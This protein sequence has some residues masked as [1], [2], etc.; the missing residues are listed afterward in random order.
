ML[1]SE[2]T[3][4][5]VKKLSSSRTLV[6]LLNVHRCSVLQRRKCFKRPC[7]VLNVDRRSNT[8]FR[9]FNQKCQSDNTECIEID[10]KN[11]GGWRVDKALALTLDLHCNIQGE[12]KE[13]LSRSQVRKLMQN[14]NILD[15]NYNLVKHSLR[16]SK[17]TNKMKFFVNLNEN[18]LSQHSLEISKIKVDCQRQ[19]PLDVLFEDEH[20]IVVNKK[21][22]DVAHAG[23]GTSQT[24]LDKV[25]EHCMC[26]VGKTKH[27]ILP[28]GGGGGLL[29]TVS[30]AAVDYHYEKRDETHPPGIIHRL[31]RDT[32]G[33]MIFAKSHKAY[34]DLRQQFLIHGDS[35]EGVKKRYQNFN[36]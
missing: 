31:D 2:L 11:M 28:S 21:V 5:F 29:E 25:F 7:P 16:I 18:T 23:A 17:Y 19:K 1:V 6:S 22:G 9:F 10:C 27:H 35:T 13:P 3:Q 32:S 36:F 8:L 30:L 15:Q 12:Y 20:I 33:A 4:N 14:G 26:A 34:V 24:L